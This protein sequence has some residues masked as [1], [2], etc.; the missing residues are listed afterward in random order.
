MT[1]K[2]DPGRADAVIEAEG[3]KGLLTRLVLMGKPAP[4]EAERPAEAN[5][6]WV[7]RQ[8][9]PKRKRGSKTPPSIGSMRVPGKP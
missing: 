1:K 9:S 6:E 2:K 8:M 3:E 4:E 7:F 5:V